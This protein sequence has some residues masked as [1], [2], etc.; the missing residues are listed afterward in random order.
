MWVSTGLSVPKQFLMPQLLAET[1]QFGG[2]ITDVVVWVHIQKEM[3]LPSLHLITQGAY[4][5]MAPLPTCPACC[6]PIP[7]LHQPYSH[8]ACLKAASQGPLSPHPHLFIS[9][10]QAAQHRFSEERSFCPAGERGPE[11]SPPALLLQA[12][13]KPGLW[14]A[15]PAATHRTPSFAFRPPFVLG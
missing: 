4:L 7:H 5:V 2:S 6:G 3:L 12:N 14:G 13:E 1:P 9:P 10:S 15:G 11:E 8:A